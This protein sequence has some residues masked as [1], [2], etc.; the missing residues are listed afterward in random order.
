MYLTTVLC[1]HVCASHVCE[2]VGGSLV[3]PG[4]IQ[5]LAQGTQG[6]LMCNYWGEIPPS[7]PCQRPERSACAP[8]QA[9]PPWGQ[10][11]KGAGQ[12]PPEGPRTGKLAA[13]QREGRGALGRGA[14]P[15][16]PRGLTADPAA[17][18]GEP[19]VCGQNLPRAPASEQDPPSQICRSPWGQTP[20]P[21]DLPLLALTSCLMTLHLALR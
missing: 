12:A 11:P 7:S 9:F 8:S 15:A 19:S 6:G 21:R 20:R 2:C 5:K 16:E 3:V 18:K 14:G 4:H 13:P 17:C 1:V 10:G